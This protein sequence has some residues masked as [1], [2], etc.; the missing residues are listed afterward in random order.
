MWKKIIF[1]LVFQFFLL[2][3]YIDAQSC[4]GQHCEQARRTQN[5]YRNLAGQCQCSEYWTT[6]C[7]NCQ[8]V[9]GRC[10]YSGHRDNQSCNLGTCESIT[11]PSEFSGTDGCSGGGGGGLP[12]C[13]IGGS[14]S[15]CNCPSGCCSGNVCQSGTSACQPQQNPYCSVSGPTD[16]CA[17]T[18]TAYSVT[19][20]GGTNYTS[21]H[22]SES[23]IQNNWRSSPNML[24]NGSAN[25]TFSSAGAHYVVCNNYDNS[26]LKCTGNPW[27]SSYPQCGGS[28][29]ITVNVRDCAMSCSI[30]PSTQ[31]LTVGQTVNFNVSGGG[32]GINQLWGYISPTTNQAWQQVA[33]TSGAPGTA[34]FTSG[35]WTCG[36]PGSYYLVCNAGSGTGAFCSGNPW[37]GATSCG[38]SSSV[39]ITCSP[40]PVTCSSCTISS[41]DSVTLN[42]FSSVPFSASASGTNCTPFII[43]ATSTSSLVSTNP[44]FANGGF[45]NTAVSSNASGGTT[46]IYVSATM[47]GNV[48]CSK[49][50]PVTVVAPPTNT[51]IPPTNTPIPPT[52]I[53]PTPVPSGC[54]VTTSP[55]STNLLVGQSATITANVSTSATVSS[56]AFGSYNTTVATVSPSSD[57]SSPYQTVVTARAAGLSA[58]WATVTLTNGNTCSSPGGNDSDIVV[59]GPTNTPT[60][61]APTNT[62]LP[63]VTIVPPTNTPF[64]PPTIAPPTNTPTPTRTPT[65][66]PTPTPVPCFA[67]VT[68]TPSNTSVEIG[69]TGLIN[70]QIGNNGRCFALTGQITVTPSGVV[71]ATLSQTSYGNYAI[72]LT[73]VSA[74]TAT[75][76]FNAYDAGVLKASNTANVTVTCTPPNAPGSFNGVDA[77]FKIALSWTDRSSDETG[78]ELR[79]DGVPATTPYPLPANTTSYTDGPAVGLCG[80]SHT[81]SLIAVNNN[82]PAC[83]AS[84]PVT[85]I[86]KCE[87][88]KAWWGTAGGGAAASAAIKSDLPSWAPSYGSFPPT[89]VSNDLS[90]TPGL[91]I[92]STFTGF[93][94]NQANSRSWLLSGLPSWSSAI[95]KQENT[96]NAML[97]RATIKS[98]TYAVGVGVVGSQGTW[99]S[100]VSGAG[101]GNRLTLADGTVVTL[102]RRS[103]DLSFTN[104][105]TVGGNKVVLFVDGNVTISGTISASGTGMLALITAGNISVAPTVG[106]STTLLDPLTGYTVNFNPSGNSGVDI[107]AAG[108]TPH[109][110]G[111]FFAA[112]TFSTGAVDSALGRYRMLRIDGSVIGLEGV[113]LQRDV[114]GPYPAEYVSFRPD[115]TY[116]LHQIG[117]RKKEY[118]ELLEP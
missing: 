10:E 42:T 63:G 85:Q 97:D 68:L 107:R 95:A 62:P 50:V 33:Y 35:S 110:T 3:G 44:T 25:F 54:T 15:N 114:R 77:V 23:W 37:G 92:G 12:S 82:K 65:P 48:Q 112:G 32:W 38:G 40:P 81:Y 52:P 69:T 89:F 118:Q 8:N 66:T 11:S 57:V 24:Q 27:P 64:I 2:P 116:N 21:L 101:V 26:T 56:V 103:G 13:N 88:Y 72:T 71:N 74:G 73:P 1:L 117:F 94:P 16:V 14:C 61:V 99:D 7:A 36:S 4:T 86:V 105:I 51:P 79:R 76:V 39:L 91:V 22:W 41:P 108:Y 34:T 19:S 106:D 78:F 9:N 93:D 18:P 29:R 28:P 96:Y 67:G 60:P 5:V 53:P 115:Y 111:V 59:T 87:D 58:V 104:P 80:P 30:S 17:G 46:S 20:G 100:L 75:V 90:G 83:R 102:L 113:S 84:A 6:T 109:L 45:V 47:N 49:V 98:T 43:S 31:N 55:V 70:A